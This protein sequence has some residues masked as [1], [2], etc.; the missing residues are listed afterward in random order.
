MACYEPFGGSQ[1]LNNTLSKNIMETRM[2]IYGVWY[3]FIPE[4]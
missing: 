3:V 4:L 2:T 1:F